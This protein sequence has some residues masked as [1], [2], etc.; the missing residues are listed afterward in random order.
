M[1][2]YSSIIYFTRRE[3]NEVTEIQV[4]WIVIRDLNLTLYHNS[5][6]PLSYQLQKEMNKRNVIFSLSC[7]D[8]CLFSRQKQWVW[9]DSS[10]RTNSNLIQFFYFHSGQRKIHF[11][12]KLFHIFMNSL[13]KRH[14]G[15]DILHICL[16]A[17]WKMKSE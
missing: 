6:F 13:T 12:E 14:N 9:P 2:R 4:N 5:V 1:T 7:N 17:H 11:A 3:T 15:S 16:F 10:T 8:R